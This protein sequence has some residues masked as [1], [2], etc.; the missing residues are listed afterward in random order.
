M[1]NVQIPALNHIK[2][3]LTRVIGIASK[4]SKS[5][6]D[7]VYTGCIHLTIRPSTAIIDMV[8][9]NLISYIQVSGDTSEARKRLGNDWKSLIKKAVVV[10]FMRGY[11][12]AQIVQDDSSYSWTTVKE[13]YGSMKA[14]RMTNLLFEVLSANTGGFQIIG[15]GF[16]FYYNFTLEVG[17]DQFEDWAK[18]IL[19]KEFDSLKS[20]N[21][22]SPQ[23]YG[24]LATINNHIVTAF[25][26][27]TPKP[28]LG[29][30]EPVCL[31]DVVFNRTSNIDLNESNNSNYY[32]LHSEG[33]SP[34]SMAYNI[35]F[36]TKLF[37]EV[38][39]EIDFIN[40]IYF[41]IKGSPKVEVLELLTNVAFG[42]SYTDG[43]LLS[44]DISPFGGGGNKGGKDPDGDNPSPEN[45]N[46]KDDSVS[47]EEKGNN[48]NSEKGDED[49]GSND[50][51]KGSNNE[52]KSKLYTEKDLKGPTPKSENSASGNIDS[53]LDESLTEMLGDVLSEEVKG[54][55]RDQLQE[56]PNIKQKT[57]IGKVLTKIPGLAGT[58][59]SNVI[60]IAISALYLSDR[61][62]TLEGNTTSTSLNIGLKGPSISRSNTKTTLQPVR[63]KK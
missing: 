1:S 37:Q 11:Y 63:R 2:G 59:V 24:I 14:T 3:S 49:K 36:G 34:V 39:L 35:F 43:Q 21:Y 30:N 32:V 27:E 13:A 7:R 4:L 51:N 55:V 53:S 6:L 23:Y 9:A 56:T 28:T 46:Q 38:I 12:L 10:D 31:G 19:G 47:N 48:S 26:L 25:Y 57:L 45:Q 52:S 20:S 61:N 17:I 15:T 50:S 5:T 40:M 29:S 16:R 62:R 22:K 42:I 44:D 41:H 58:V 8:T 33:V 18:S 54:L 60:P